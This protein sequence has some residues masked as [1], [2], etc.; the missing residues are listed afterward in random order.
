MKTGD[1]IK[2]NMGFLGTITKI[3]YKGAAG[4]GCSYVYKIEVLLDNSMK[5]IVDPAT[6][7][8]IE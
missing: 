5:M 4:S 1:K 8:L 6:I 2:T 7:T 3:F